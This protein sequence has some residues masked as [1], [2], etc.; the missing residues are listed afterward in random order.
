M[1]KALTYAGDEICELFLPRLRTLRIDASV[2]CCVRLLS[3]TS[4]HT[5]DIVATGK[6]VRFR[7]GPAL[8]EV[9]FHK[10]MSLC[11]GHGV[12]TPGRRGTLQTVMNSVLG[13]C[14]DGSVLIMLVAASRR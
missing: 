7:L 10:E 13:G 2:G 1:A 9:E 14:A 12:Y 4:L 6:S 5:L 3:C 8:G 11:L